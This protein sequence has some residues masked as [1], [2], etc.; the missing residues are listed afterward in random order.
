MEGVQ[1]ARAG[2]QLRLVGTNVKALPDAVR[3]GLREVKHLLLPL[4]GEDPVEP[5][6]LR[7]PTQKEPL[8]RCPATTRRKKHR[9]RHTSQLVKA[10]GT[11]WLDLPIDGRLFPAWNQLGAASGRTSCKGPNLQ[12]VPKDDRYRRC[13]V[14]PPGRVFVKADY[15]QLQRRLAAKIADEPTMM[16]AYQKGRDL[17]TLTARNITGKNG[18]TKEER[19][20]AKVL[21]FGLL[22]GMGVDRLREYARQEYGVELSEE[23][24]KQHRSSFFASYP[25]LAERHNQAAREQ[26]LARL[27]ERRKNES[28]TILGRHRLFDAGTPL[29]FRLATPVQGS[30]ADGA[31]LA[32]AL[33]WERREQCPGAFPVLFVHDELVIEVDENRADAAAEW[34]KQAMVEGM[35]DILAPVPCEVEVSIGRT[36]GG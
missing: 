17:H 5:M 15:N 33:L 27:D 22:F 7:H 8:T 31:K 12:Q 34:L 35:K 36:W 13:F 9:H 30:E 21:N 29:T 26:H 20:L 28:R 3:E 25:A 18:V 6:T 1:I 2:D 24:A 19:Q 4:L 32:M 16:K 23:D 10:F 14:A 11:S